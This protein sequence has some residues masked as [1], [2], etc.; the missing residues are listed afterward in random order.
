M[1]ERQ[2]YPSR[3]TA[4]GDA[5][6]PYDV[7]GWTLPLQ[8]GVRSVEVAGRFPVEAERLDRVEPIRGAILGAGDPRSFALRHPANDDFLV[9]NALL[10]AGVEVLIGPSL[11]GVLEFA[12]DAKSKAVLDRVLP[13]VSSQ[14]TGSSRAL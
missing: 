7:A 12:A 14:V 6:A 3:F 5:E 4:K 2:A 13:T 11:P 9:L 1:M 8:M 10:A